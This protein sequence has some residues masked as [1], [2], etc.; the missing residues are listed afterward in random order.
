MY[1]APSTPIHTS[2]TAWAWVGLAVNKPGRR[3]PFSLRQGAFPR[4]G[5]LGALSASTAS[6][7]HSDAM[8]R[9]AAAIVART[10]AAAH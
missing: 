10:F 8:A 9:N 6:S 2:F 5:W 4:L 3:G 1:A 7:V